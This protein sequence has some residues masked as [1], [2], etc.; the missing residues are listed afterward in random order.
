MSICLIVSDEVSDDS[1]KTS[2]PKYNG[3]GTEGIG[4]VYQYQLLL[5]F[6]AD[7]IGVDY[8]FSGTTN[9]SHHAYTEYS[10]EGFCQSL[11]NFFN[12]SNL[13]KE[14]DEVH[15][16]AQLESTS[17]PRGVDIFNG[18]L[19]SFRDDNKDKD[20]LVNLH[21]CHVHLAKFCAQ[22]VAEIF[23]KERID[24]IRSRLVFEG[25]KYFEDGL[26]ISWHVRSANPSDIPVEIVSPLRELYVPDRDFVRYRNLINFLKSSTEGRKTTLH[27]HSQGFV[28][29]FEEFLDLKE[30]DFNVRIHLDDPPVSDI[31]H[32]ANADLFVM[33]NSSF[34]WVPSLLNSNQKIVRDNFTNRPFVHNHIKANYDFTKFA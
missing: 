9:L 14:W 1:W 20:I 31:Y 6:Y 24:R 27:L 32:M 8:T 23:T 7:F 4:S 22:H 11:D 17:D 3:L 15:M 18:E 25:E 21:W 33:S 30:N 13:K 29:K 26:N 5:A 34:S 28:T 12:F 2:I 10:A 19:L 16:F